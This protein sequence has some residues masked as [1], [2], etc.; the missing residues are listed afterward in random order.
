MRVMI[1]NP[2]TLLR[3]ILVGVFNDVADVVVAAAVASLGE[4]RGSCHRDKP[5][6]V[7]A[8]TSFPDGPM[9]DAIADV[10]VIGARVLVVC[11]AQS[12][13]SAY[14]L[15][16]AGASGCLFVEDAGPVEVV[17]ATRAVAAGNAALHPAIAAAVLQQ[18]RSSS[19]GIA[20]D[21]GSSVMALDSEVPPLTPREAEVLRAL[22][23]GLPTKTIGR[24]M[25]VSPKTVEAH[26]A[27]LL[28]KLKARHRAHAVSVALDL[29]L[30]DGKGQRNGER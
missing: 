30:L 23:R 29:G 12:A 16:F 24:E 17:E 11:D 13:V 10:L 1:A 25:S 9:A 22:A 7:L 28:A 2:S 18:W 26:I 3:S 21:D 14:G 4:L 19:R 15:L 5:H 27:R 6:V 8:G 20:A